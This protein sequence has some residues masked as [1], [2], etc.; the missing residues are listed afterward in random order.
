MLEDPLRRRPGFVSFVYGGRLLDTT[1]AVRDVFKDSL[2][3][4]FVEDREPT[5]VFV[6]ACWTTTLPSKYDP[7]EWV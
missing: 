6:I 4:V 3:F 2:L 7:S 1:A 5:K